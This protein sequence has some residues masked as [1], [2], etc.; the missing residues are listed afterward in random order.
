MGPRVLFVDDEPEVCEWG[1]AGLRRRG[2]TVE[3]RTS[4]ADAIAYLEGGDP[5]VV[6]TDLSMPAMSGLEFCQ[7]VVAN[8]PDLPVIV[9]TAFGSLDV[10]IGAIRSGAYDFLSKPFDIDVLTIAVERAAQNHRLRAEVKRLRAE[11]TSV[12][13]SGLL[14][15]S[16]VMRELR[17][18][19]GQVSQ[20]PS[21]A[22]ITGESG[23]GKE[24]A[25]RI[26]HDRSARKDGPFVAINCAAMPEA[27]L[28]AELF[29]HARGAFT[30]AK[31]ARPGLFTQAD[32]G[33]LFLDEVGDMPLGLQSKILRALEERRVR[34]VGGMGEVPFDVRFVA[35]T[36]H[37]LESAV[38]EGRFRA[39]LFYRLNV[40]HIA[41]PPLRERPGDVVLLAQRFLEELAPRFGK[42]VTGMSV[43]VVGRLSAYAWPGNVRELR[44]CIERAVALTRFAELT[45]DDL[46][47]RVRAYQPSHIVV[48]SEQASE[49]V[50]L[51]EVE[52][53]YIGRVLE[54]VQ[55]NKTL[56]AKV[57][58]LDRATLYRKLER[59]EHK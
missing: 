14:G 4:A 33:T 36:N 18:L 7:R 45:V 3:W 56:A 41:M 1:A 32:G 35:A 38:E 57:L 58:G 43:A 44:N 9:T 28:E 59:Y 40:I 47:E 26:I 22:L 17:A 37:D 8:R 31:V 10:A 24:V 12:D 21:T 46:P 25:A 5:E 51:E 42:P 55:G 49:L 50:T 53:R 39:D 27:L 13:A 48:A 19:L 30:D 16:T 15:E 6:V 23:T 2:C 34:P 20:T 54:A 11:R 52:R 29:G